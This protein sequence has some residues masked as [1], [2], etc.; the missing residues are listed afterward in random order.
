[1]RKY[2]LVAVLIFICLVIVLLSEKGI[3][4]AK[5]LFSG[6]NIENMTE[7][8][9]ETCDN[10]SNCNNGIDCSNCTDKNYSNCT[11]S[12]IFKIVLDAGHG[13]NDPGKVGVNN[14][15]E[16]DINLSITLKLK[17]FLEAKGVTVVLT[18]T[19]DSALYSESDKNKKAADLVKRV[20]IIED[21]DPDIAVSIH[22]NSFTESSSKGVQVFYYDTSDKSKEFAEVVQEKIKEKIMDGNHRLAKA[23]NSYYLLKKTS[24][25]II[26]VEC[27]FL[28]N[29]TEAA[30][31]MTTE[32]QDKMSIAIGESIIEYM[33][34]NNN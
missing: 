7:N 6:K 30:L 34:G 26:I 31:L 11:K 13:G 2:R 8:M 17:E 18:R 28:S 16:K 24:C 9:E 21:A 12:K 10:C 15:L 5:E 1:M 14:A 32:Y 33:T 19:T 25:P 23:N 29:P 20:K 4:K 27:G 3:E 22:Q